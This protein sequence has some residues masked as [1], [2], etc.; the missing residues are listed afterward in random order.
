MTNP[1]WWLSCRA[2][3][4]C[5]MS[6]IAHLPVHRGFTSSFGYLSGA[7]DH[8]ADTRSGYVDLWRSSR[9]AY[10]ENGSLAGGYDYNTYKFTREAV[11][12]VEAHPAERPLFIYLAY[13][14]VRH[15]IGN[16]FPHYY[17]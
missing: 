13:Q 11:H 2:Q 9:A 15:Y 6:C 1:Q 12:I 7:E 17:V 16:S 5:G 4:H 8:Y 10:G 14:N 3:W